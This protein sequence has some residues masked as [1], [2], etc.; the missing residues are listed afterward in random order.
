MINITVIIEGNRM[1]DG[2]N[3]AGIIEGDGMGDAINITFIIEG[4]GN[5]DASSNINYLVKGL[6][7]PAHTQLFFSRS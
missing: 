2:I 1:G 4:N 3:I 6:D 7:P 5:G